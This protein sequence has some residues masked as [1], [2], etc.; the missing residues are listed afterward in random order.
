MIK[1]KAAPKIINSNA[2]NDIP[3]MNSA[4]T[5]I[6]AVAALPTNSRR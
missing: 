3:P 6:W 5:R 4:K 2:P 1:T